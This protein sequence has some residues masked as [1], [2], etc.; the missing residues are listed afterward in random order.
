MKEAS[1]K[2]KA[3]GFLTLAA[4]GVF[5]VSGC[6]EREDPGV[7]AET[8]AVV[9]SNVPVK[10]VPVAPEPGKVEAVL[11][12]V[13]AAPDE[14]LVYIEVKKAEASSFDQT[15]DWAPS[16]NPMNACD[17][18]MLTR[19]SSDYHEGDQWIS[20]DLGQES[21]VS[22]VIVRWERAY[23]TDHKILGSNDGVSWK[24]LHR[25][26]EFKGGT[27]DVEFTP[28]KCRYVKVL[29]KERVNEDWGISIWETEIYGP[30]SHNPSATITKEEYLTSE[31]DKDARKEADEALNNLAQPV[32]PLSEN[33]FQKGL[34]YT[35]WMGEEFLSPVSD[36]TLAYLRDA[37]YDSIAIMVPAYQ[38]SIDSKVVFANDTPDGDTPTDEALRHV[39]ASSRKIGMR[40]MLKPHIDPRT[41]EPRV[42]IM[43]S[44]EWFDSFEELTLRYARLAAETGAE[45]FCVGTEL[46]ATTFDAWTHRWEGLIEKV[47]EIYGGILTYAANWTEYKEVPFWDKLDYIGID[48]YF[49]LSAVEDPSLEDLIAS[50]TRIADEIEKWREARG[51]TDMGVVL[52][53]IGYPSARGSAIQP[54]VAISG[55]EDQKAQA[56]SLEAVFT[57]LSERPWFEGYYVWQYFPQD[58]WSPLGFTVKGKMAEEVMDKWL[59]VSEQ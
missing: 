20:F 37:G 5:A 44:E 14:L 1:L 26:K 57:A 36:I 17:G 25:E 51:L 40:V 38:D 27:M 43:P 3:A 13:E 21:V 11:E 45:I 29:G 53:E 28:V 4:I 24:E 33:P 7:K 30:A 9:K 15:P 50:W 47:R 16:P 18:D 22:N 39:I 6:G 49:P 54:W 19:W 31:E 8:P 56:D 59:T 2:R 35:S 12:T 48:A 58:R 46:E 52:T 32:V 55:I 42:N 41:D 34:V 23:A 10:E